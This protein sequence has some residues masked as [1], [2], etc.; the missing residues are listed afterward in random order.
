M[1]QERR[2]AGTRNTYF[3]SRG[4]S[5]TFF[6]SAEGNVKKIN[7]PSIWLPI[8]TAAHPVLFCAWICTKISSVAEGMF[9]AAQILPPGTQKLCR[10][11]V[12]GDELGDELEAEAGEARARATIAG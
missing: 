11:E 5:V 7:E 8:P 12:C 4:E 1:V 10:D 6:P 2:E 3:P 9:I